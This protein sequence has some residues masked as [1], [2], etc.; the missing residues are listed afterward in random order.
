MW[1]IEPTFSPVTS[2]TS[3]PGVMRPRYSRSDTGSAIIAYLLQLVASRDAA[4]RRDLPSARRTAANR[5]PAPLRRRGDRGLGSGGAR[6]MSELVLGI[7]IGTSSS[8]G[9]LA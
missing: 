7:D 4:S 2:Q 5:V 8:K 9:V 1:A 6:R 3:M